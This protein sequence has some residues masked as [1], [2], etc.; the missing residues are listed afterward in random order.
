MI[1][2]C[3]VNK[4]RELYY[5]YENKLNIDIQINIINELSKHEE[6][7]EYDSIHEWD[8]WNELLYIQKTKF[9]PKKL[10][11]RLEICC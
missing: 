4:N 11:L 1:K 3:V 7:L 6:L 5:V 2:A 9:Y 10:T 8:K